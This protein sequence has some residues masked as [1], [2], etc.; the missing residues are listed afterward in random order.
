MNLEL[1][2]VLTPWITF[3]AI[4]TLGIIGWCIRW[5]IGENNR[6]LND[7]KENLEDMDN[8]FRELVR[9]RQDD[10]KYIFEQICR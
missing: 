4:L 3:F 8:A 7:F 5:M 9:A 1:L 10:Q 2:K 6:R